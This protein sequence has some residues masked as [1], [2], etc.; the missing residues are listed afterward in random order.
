MFDK[1]MK[2]MI[3]VLHSNQKI[4]LYPPKVRSS[5]LKRRTNTIDG[6]ILVQAI[7]RVLLVHK[8]T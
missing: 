2:T 3:L 6:I 7:G 8:I 1:F 5:K 4:F